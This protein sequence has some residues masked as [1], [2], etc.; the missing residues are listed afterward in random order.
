MDGAACCKSGSGADTPEKLLRCFHCHGLQHT[1]CCPEIDQR[2]CSDAFLL[3]AKPREVPSWVRD[4]AAVDVSALSRKN[5]FCP[6][7]LVGF[8]G[9]R[10]PTAHSHAG[11]QGAAIEVRLVSRNLSSCQNHGEAVLEMSL[12]D[13][14]PQIHVRGEGDSLRAFVDVMQINGLY[15]YDCS[16]IKAS[17]ARTFLDARCW[18]LPHPSDAERCEFSLQLETDLAPPPTLLRR[19][20]PLH[21]AKGP[22]KQ[23]CGSV[24]IGSGS[25]Y[26]SMECEVLWRADPGAPGHQFVKTLLAEDFTTGHQQDAFC[27]S[28]RVAFCSAVDSDHADHPSV[29][30]ILNGGRFFARIPA[31]EKWIGNYASVQEDGEGYRLLPLTQVI[32]PDV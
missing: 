17:G 21:P 27:T 24:R 16:E 15:G 18:F 9:R 28:C 7:C 4:L 19:L 14:V 25:L 8:S 20:V 31:T 6:T 30:I 22:T 32:G 12:V 5:R 26:C 13:V 3:E 29:E 23:Y 11:G 10:C 1:S 2:N